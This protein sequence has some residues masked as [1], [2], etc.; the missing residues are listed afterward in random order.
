[1][2]T[3]DVYL[4][5]KFAGLLG[6][7]Q[8]EVTNMFVNALQSPKV[9]S[10]FKKKIAPMMMPSTGTILKS[11]LPIVGLAGGTYLLGKYMELKNKA[12]KYFSPNAPGN[13]YANLLKR[14]K[15]DINVPAQMYYNKQPGFYNSIFGLLRKQ[16]QT[17]PFRFKTSGEYF[18]FK[19]IV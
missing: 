5:Y 10:I 15:T 11:A 1:M 4:L 8:E 9:L 14:I 6:P 12:N 17:S 13:V 18:P 2:R 3:S 16:V 7:S 19:G